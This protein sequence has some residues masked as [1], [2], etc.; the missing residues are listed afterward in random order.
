MLLSALPGFFPSTLVW[1]PVGDAAFNAAWLLLFLF[2]GIGFVRIVAT[3]LRH[4]ILQAALLLG[5]WTARSEDKAPPLPLPIPAEAVVRILD[6]EGV[7]S[8]LLPLDHVKALEDKIRNLEAPV[9][10][11]G[12]GLT[13]MG[14][15][16]ELRLDDQE[17]LSLVAVYRVRVR[18]A[19]LQ[20]LPL[21]ASSA[22]MTRVRLNGQPAPLHRRGETT[23]IWLQ[24][25]GSHT[26]SLEM[27]VPVRRQELRWEIDTHLLPAPALIIALRLPRAGTEVS[28]DKA[29]VI[30]RFTSRVEN[31]ELLLPVAAN[32]RLR[33]EW[34]SAD[35]NR[36]MTEG[37]Q[38]TSDIFFETR[39][40]LSVLRWNL[41]LQNPGRPLKE[42]D[43]QV[44]K[45]WSVHSVLGTDVG[46]WEWLPATDAP[47]AEETATLRVHF[48]REIEGR[49]AFNLELWR[50]ADADVA[51]APRRESL[52][53]L[54]VAEAL[55]HTGTLQ[56]FRAPQQQM[57][58][59]NS[60]G[61]RRIDVDA[62]TLAK[63]A[64]VMPGLLD[65]PVFFQGYSFH[66]P[67]HRLDLD[68]AGLPSKHSATWERIFRLAEREQMLEALCRIQISGT[69]LHQLEFSLPEGME[70][71]SVMT[72]PESSW[73]ADADVL[74]IFSGTGLIGDV[75]VLIQGRF[76]RDAGDQPM[77]LPR[78]DLRGAETQKGQWA[79][80][81]D[82]A[83]DVD[84]RD[85]QNVEPLLLRQTHT[86][87][88]APQHPFARLALAFSQ[89][90]H[91]ARLLLRKRLPD[92]SVTSF[93][94]LRINHRIIEETLLLE[95][96]V[97][98]AGLRTLQVEIPERFADAE[99]KA[100]LLRDVKMTPIPD[101]PGWLEMT[102][103]LQDEIM[104]QIVILLEKDRSLDAGPL[105]VQPPRIVTGRAERAFVTIENAGRDE[106]HVSA[107]Q[108]LEALTREHA[109]WAQ[110]TRVLKG[111]ATFAY[112]GRGNQRDASLTLQITERE[113]AVTSGA[114]IGLARAELVL[115]ESG[116]YRGRWNAWLDNRSEA[117]LHLEM[118][119]GAQVLGVSVAGREVRPLR[120]PGGNPA[121]LRIPLEKTPAGGGDIQV[122]LLYGGEIESFASLRVRGFPFPKASGIPVALSQTQLHL[123]RGRRWFRF[124]GSMNL[125]EDPT[126]F[127]AG[128]L[129]YQTSLAERLAET[130][131]SGD[132][133]E[134]ARATHNLERLNNKI[135][136]TAQ[137]VRRRSNDAQVQQQ[138]DTS[139]QILRDAQQQVAQSRQQEAVAVDG[140]RDSL[141]G[142]FETQTNSFGRNQVLLNVPNFTPDEIAPNPGQNQGKNAPSNYNDLRSGWAS[143][144]PAIL[145]K[146][147]VPSKGSLDQ[148]VHQGQQ[149]SRQQ[150]AAEY[151]SRLDDNTEERSSDTGLAALFP[152]PDPQQYQTFPFSTPRGDMH[153]TVW[154]LS[155][156]TI[157]AWG[158]FAACLVCG[159]LLLALFRRRR[160]RS[161]TRF[162]LFPA[163]L[164]M[165]F[166]IL[167]V[168]SFFLML[169][170]LLS[171]FRQ[172]H[173]RFG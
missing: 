65:A 138:A 28:F 166:G 124:D 35:K 132:E 119:E 106:I 93:T 17:T 104:G 52:P 75:Q 6:G 135:D 3:P 49:V 44:S 26:L 171:M 128:W 59:R 133:Y 4:R 87:L 63:T 80:L 173:S 157:S 50:K 121:A 112:V 131:K 145:S 31:E 47:E 151:L 165:A 139:E 110:A 57:Q 41:D 162:L 70:I 89:S 61:L 109:E 155:E 34:R 83:F 96:Q 12:P 140:N 149:G 81:S 172:R 10:E 130:L 92:I 115:D 148:K 37:L 116:A 84:V 141:N 82:P 16:A 144:N 23:E 71:E 164:G 168:F 100:P 38:V 32:G 94:N 101:A 33:L 103:E 55:R 114:R 74:R 113:Q 120:D 45:G 134:K 91:D 125:V 64:V 111:G 40:A 30:P 169:Y 142:F 146:S 163:L 39:P 67:G 18:G 36:P 105:V 20:T 97:Q 42:V 129:G 102:I 62:Q 58:V 73:S 19:G 156:K 160:S 123:P 69:P 152:Q 43:L 170:A 122:T 167:P 108:R 5:A 150:L 99:V 118:P 90:E 79:I 78:L 159:L 51:G 21:P 54:R 153:I 77:A 68:L 137:Q 27:R 11:A 127:E 60:E 7:E 25:E 88:K 56:V 117:F 147:G 143:S 95:A 86:W 76:K 66:S 9:V 98:H 8:W 14:G 158:R 126:R 1:I 48:R 154:S 53:I 22:Q 161:R 13:W 136:V 15:R 46:G 2:L 107:A 85:L 29:A 24:G 72:P